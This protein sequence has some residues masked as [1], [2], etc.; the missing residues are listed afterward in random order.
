MASRNVIRSKTDSKNV[1]YI[2]RKMEK[3]D[4]LHF[5]CHKKVSVRTFIEQMF[6]I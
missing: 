3:R 1:I 6:D 4:F 2:M 5:L